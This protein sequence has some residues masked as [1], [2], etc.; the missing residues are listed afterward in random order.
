[1]KTSILNKI[2]HS[3]KTFLQRIRQNK[4][5]NMV[6]Y[7]NGFNES[8]EEILQ[9]NLYNERLEAALANL[10]ANST[11]CQAGTLHLQFQDGVSVSLYSGCQVAG[12]QVP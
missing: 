12:P 4:T 6:N 2:A 11:P 7:D 3:V 9:D 10:L 8:Y 5:G 1:M